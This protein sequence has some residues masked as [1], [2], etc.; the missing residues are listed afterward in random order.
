MSGYV[1]HNLKTQKR[2]IPEIGIHRSVC[3]IMT[4]IYL[5]R[6]GSVSRTLFLNATTNASL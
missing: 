1:G 3:D 2:R 4:A 6:A 5:K